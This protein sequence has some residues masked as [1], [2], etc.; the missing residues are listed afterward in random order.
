MDTAR[1]EYA[2]EVTSLDR[3]LKDVIEDSK[4]THFGNNL[5]AVTAYEATLTSSRQELEEEY[6]KRKATADAAAAK[7]A[8][9]QV[10]DFRYTVLTIE[11]IEQRKKQ[12]DGL[13]DARVTAYNEELSRQKAME[14]KRL[15]FA[16][17]AQ[18]FVDFLAAQKKEI[19]AVTGEPE[20]K[21]DTV[22]KLYNSGTQGEE[23]L[24]ALKKVDEEALAMGIAHN[25]HTDLS[26]KLLES[27]WGSFQ[28][29]VKNYLASLTDDL[30]SKKQAETRRAEVE[31]RRHI[32]NLKIECAQLAGVLN[33]AFEATSEQTGAPLIAKAP[34]DVTAMQEK[35]AAA[36]T[37]KGEVVPPNLAKLGEISN[38]LATEG[39]TENP[40]AELSLTEANE[41]NA[42]ADQAIAQR[43]TELAAELEKQKTIESLC[44][45]FAEKAEAFNTSLDAVNSK[46]SN[47]TGT[48]EE[49][50][51]A[52]DAIN[53]DIT[54]LR[55]QLEELQ[56]AN[57]AV[58]DAG[59]TEN[60]HTKLTFVL[61]EAKNKQVCKAAE[62]KRRVLAS[63]VE[64]AKGS[65][66]SEEQM[67]ELKEAF[68]YFDKDGNGIF[69]PSEFKACVGSLG[70]D[71]SDEAV[72][73]VFTEYGTNGQMN[74]DGYVRYMVN[75]LSD[76]TDPSEIIDSFNTISGG[77]PFVT[78]QQI[79]QYFPDKAEYLMAN[80]PAG[81]E[82][83]T[84]DFKKYTE[85]I[86]SR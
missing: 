33:Q 67:K 46:I 82:P 23:L 76:K 80:M 83:N 19:I 72:T 32:E 27:R 56:K 45:A 10:S 29:F 5:E 50:I 1:H 57:Q 59:V 53:S 66:V 15:E 6:S 69:T 77:K 64:Q 75:R 28:A 22:T 71:L 40:L 34:A 62:D 43:E 16:K 74:F 4:D 38:Q 2:K 36:K 70:E 26:Y 79:K 14:E 81:P 8:E 61:L 86:F 18:E 20:E 60:T 44:I 3:W 37:S 11:S 54:P 17:L 51:V 39:V 13:L 52:L 25:K 78:D 47:T 21:I 31:K 68:S 12:L 35:L 58:I 84:F 65:K 73:K 63:T 55:A 24:A 41:K 85:D 9:L 42:S 7:L 30:E 48:P 49:Q